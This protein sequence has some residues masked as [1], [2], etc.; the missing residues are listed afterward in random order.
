[1]LEGALDRLTARGAAQVVVVCPVNLAGKAKLLESEGLS[2]GAQWWTRPLKQ[3]GLTG[4]VQR[5]D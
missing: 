3:K 1:L 4:A 2:V 5:F